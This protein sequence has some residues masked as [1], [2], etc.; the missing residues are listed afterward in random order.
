M[1]I[2][3]F[4]KNE[5]IENL[6]FDDFCAYLESFGNRKKAEFDK[7]I[8]RSNLKIFGLNS[9]QVSAIAK[10]LKTHNCAKIL[11]YPSD[12]SYEITLFQGLI[13]ADDKDKDAKSRYEDMRPI[14]NYFENWAH[15]DSVMSK[16]RIKKGEEETAF[17]FAESL[18][19]GEKEFEIRCGIII[20]LSYFLDKKYIDR[21]FAALSDIEYG[22]YYYVDMAVAWLC[23]T[24]LIDFKTETLNFL[25]D[26]KNINDFT[27]C[28]SLQKARESRRISDEDKIYYK[29]L[30]LKKKK[31]LKN[32][33]F[34]K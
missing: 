9:P 24:A 17:S 6:D 29:S 4:Y 5:P 11:S 20:L 30:I 2:E 3:F 10:Y 13:L 19:N 32:Q 27:Y 21:V 26:N 34:F 31:L 7:K 33:H 16:L 14:I 8:I 28:K 1:D 15:C 25:N 22:R 18:L 12:F 23:A